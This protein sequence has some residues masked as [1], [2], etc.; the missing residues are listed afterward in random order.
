MTLESLSYSPAF[1]SNYPYN[2][3]PWPGLLSPA[4]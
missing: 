1:S 4:G 2:D 3:H